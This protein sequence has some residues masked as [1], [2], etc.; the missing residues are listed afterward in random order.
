[1]YN[2]KERGRFIMQTNIKVLDP[3][4]MTGEK[5]SCGNEAG[6]ILQINDSKPQH[7]CNICIAEVGHKVI[8]ALM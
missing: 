2:K 7:L 8:Q 5:C 4:G 3:V 6:F 1:M